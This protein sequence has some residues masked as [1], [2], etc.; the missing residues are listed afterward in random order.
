MKRCSS[1]HIIE[2][3]Q[4]QLNKSMTSKRVKILLGDGDADMQELPG[5]PL[6]EWEI[7]PLREKITHRRVY[8]SR[9]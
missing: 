3:I 8:G 9:L 7:F 1:V 2:Q 5:G 4:Y 6:T